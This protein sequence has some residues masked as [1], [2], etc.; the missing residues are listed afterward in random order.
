MALTLSESAKLSTDMLQRGVIETII[1]ESPLFDY[2][3]FVTVEGNS[4]KYNQENALG[5][6]GH[7]FH[8]CLLYG[9]TYFSGLC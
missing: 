3:P 2:L 5:G 1:E 9:G 6:A 4:F 8:R 7:R